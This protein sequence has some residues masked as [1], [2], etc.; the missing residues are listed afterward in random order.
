M[1]NAFDAGSTGYFQ[2]ACDSVEHLD[3]LNILSA[4]NASPHRV[5]ALAR[6]EQR[7]HV[8]M[9]VPEMAKTDIV[10]MSKAVITG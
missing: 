5:L 3:G 10:F 7:E 2:I 8:T 4:G 1:G 6:E 9:N